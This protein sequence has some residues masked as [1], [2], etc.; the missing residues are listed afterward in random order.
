MGGS[1]PPPSPDESQ[2]T[3]LFVAS[4]PEMLRYIMA[5]I[6]SPIDARDVLQET[7]VA[8]WRKRGEYDPSVPFIPW[9]CRFASIEIRGFLRRRQRERRCLDDD[10]V[11]LLHEEQVR[12]QERATAADL[13]TACALRDCLERLPT[14]HHDVLRRYYFDEEPVEAISAAVGRTVDAVYKSLQRGRGWLLDCM[15][16][17]QRRLA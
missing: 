8:L 5:T 13:E 9:A 3:R 15:T 14:A 4:E 16:D 11:T 1:L 12:R 6:P 7:A 2:F 17:K 10:V